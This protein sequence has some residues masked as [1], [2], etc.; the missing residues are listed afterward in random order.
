MANNDNQPSKHRR[1]ILQGSLAAPVVLTVS[2][3]AAATVTTFSKCL[4]NH[5]NQ[6]ADAAF[7]T[8]GPDNWFRKQVPVV[9][10]QRGSQSGWFYFDP[11]LNDYVNVN[12][13]GQATRIGAM[14]E[15][16]WE[17]I[18]EDQRWALVWV[19]SK[20]GTPYSVMQVQQPM[21]YTASTTTCMMSVKPG[22]WHKK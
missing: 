10:L 19:D 4:A 2:S 3:P 11:A 22:G 14:I 12:A 9:Q 20:T 13:P 16:G 17:K 7:F 8:G 5:A 1:A 15:K 18:G 21:G 6:E